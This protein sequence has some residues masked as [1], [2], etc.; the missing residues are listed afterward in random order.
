MPESNV[1]IC[2]M[3]TASLAYLGDCVIE[4]LVRERLTMSGISSS[5]SLNKEAL[6]FVSATAQAAAMKNI[7]ELLTEEE[8]GFY[9]RGK[10]LAHM[11]VPKSATP[12]EYRVA[13]GMETLF[14]FLH[15]SGN[16]DRARELFALAY[17]VE[18]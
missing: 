5:K 18:K 3:S 14:G 13:T 11:N 9:R 17:P 7:M 8:S 10:N 15:L 4:L 2:D 1:K 6:K 16:D 12:A